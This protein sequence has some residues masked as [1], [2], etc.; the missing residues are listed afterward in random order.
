MARKNRTKRNNMASNT[1]NTD[2]N[3][4]GNG[5]S[6]VGAT[7]SSMDDYQAIEDPNTRSI[8]APSVP[9]SRR[10]HDKEANG[11][12]ME[13]NKSG[14]AQLLSDNDRAS[15]SDDDEHLKDPLATHSEIQKIKTR[16]ALKRLLITL[17]LCFTF[18]TGEFV[19]G[20]LSGSLAIM[21][22]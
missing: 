12:E 2:D 4:I 17:A 16:R 13:L 20:Y 9:W 19:G 10:S 21:T 18:M 11:M 15:L 7:A 8:Q 22:E 3:D 1:N 5:S 14:K 6:F